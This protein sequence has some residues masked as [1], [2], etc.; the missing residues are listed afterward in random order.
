MGSYPVHEDQQKEGLPLDSPRSCILVSAAGVQ[1][2]GTVGLVFF[3]TSFGFQFIGALE[4]YGQL[5]GI[6]ASS[7]ISVLVLSLYPVE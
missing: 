1:I 7:C 2:Y 3:G 6:S 4:F 5:K